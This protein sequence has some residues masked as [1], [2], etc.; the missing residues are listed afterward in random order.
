MKRMILMM[1]AAL[2][3]L[4]IAVF[5]LTRE[6][7]EQAEQ[8]ETPRVRAANRNTTAD[9]G[10]Q[11]S[12]TRSADGTMADMPHSFSTA[13]TAPTREC[14]GEMVAAMVNASGRKYSLTPNQVGNFDRVRVQPQ[15]KI[16]VTISYPGGVAGETV[17]IQAED[18][19]QFE[20]G[21]MA[22]EV[23]LDAQRTLAFLFQVTN[24][25]GEHRV[26]LRKG[27]DVKVLEFWVGEELPVAA[28]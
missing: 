20:D 26:T 12:E 8:S 18:G 14:P 7:P 28:M 10:T 15:E 24:E 27:N 22:R 21:G 6:R 3:V 11:C 9:V 2:V 16:P 17:V 25:P 13:D 1:V 4:T 19:G 23:Q 5:W